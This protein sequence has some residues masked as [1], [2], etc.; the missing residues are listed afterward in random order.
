[1]NCVK[2][3]NPIPAGAQACPVCQAPAFQKSSIRI[4]R[5]P[6]N[7]IVLSNDQVGRYHATIS[8]QGGVYTLTDNQSRNGTYLHGQRIS[9]S[10]ISPGDVIRFA[11][12][13]TLD[14][15]AV[16][17][18]FS[19]SRPEAPRAQQPYAAPPIAGGK[20]LR[21]GRAPDNDIVFSQQ[22]VS[23]YHAELVLD[24]D[25]NSGTLRD[26]GSKAG[27][28][29]NGRPCGSGTRVTRADRVVFG[30][31][32]VLS[33]AGIDGAPAPYQQ[34]YNPPSPGYQ[35]Q[36]YQPAKPQPEA[37]PSNWK[38][39]RNSKS[40]PVPLILGIV[41]AVVVI[42][43]A[44]F[45]ISGGS[46]AALN[47][48]NK[49]IK[50]SGAYPIREGE[51]QALAMRRARIE[52]QR[53]LLEK[54]KGMFPNTSGFAK[55]FT[56]FPLN[57]TDVRYD[58]YRNE[59]RADAVTAMNNPD[60]MARMDYLNKQHGMMDQITRAQSSFDSNYQLMSDALDNLEMAVAQGYMEEELT[61]FSMSLEETIGALESVV[62][63]LEPLR[64]ELANIHGKHRKGGFGGIFSRIGRG[65]NKLFGGIGGGGGG[66]ADPMDVVLRS[67]NMDYTGEKDYFDSFE[68][69]NGSRALIQKYFQSA[70]GTWQKVKSM[71]NQFNV[72]Y[73]A[74]DFIRQDV[75][76]NT[77]YIKITDDCIRRVLQ[78]VSPDSEEMLMDY[79]RAQKYYFTKEKGHW[80]RYLHTEDSQRQSFD[81]GSELQK[82]MQ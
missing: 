60:F 73:S 40:S 47:A 34:Q 24:P 64:A 70:G 1:M 62:S 13:E 54:T 36:P 56:V 76:S 29:V 35:Q 67:M 48:E 65:F 43:V 2:C 20:K 51:S 27:T 59:I 81:M 23:R 22:D 7:D 25:G 72:R 26:I 71:Q 16:L 79:M 53:E 63:S 37:P 57:I 15:N 28:S 6:D 9:I 8:C 19:G 42:L 55:N 4:G 38:H 49:E 58:D 45:Y 69:A 52:A 32:A 5:A 80:K 14:W 50:H 3:G 21:I 39:P 10:R 30:S 82:L 33:W 12:V 46:D 11:N 78:A 66:G 77:F 75:D 41:A 31:S 17:A 44:F 61:Q 74:A 68:E 18:A